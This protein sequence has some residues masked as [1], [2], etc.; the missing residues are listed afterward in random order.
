MVAAGSVVLRL[1]FFTRI[2]ANAPRLLAL[3]C[4]ALPSAAGCHS[5]EEHGPGTACDDSHPCRGGLVCLGTC[6]P[7]PDAG[8]DIT[9]DVAPDGDVSSLPAVMPPDAP[10]ADLAEAGP[11]FDLP[12][13][14][15]TGDSDAP[16]D[17]ATDVADAS[18]TEAMPEVEPDL[19]PDAVPDSIDSGS[20]LSSPYPPRPCDRTRRFERIRPLDGLQSVLGSHDETAHLTPDELT[21][22]FASSRIDG[23]SIYTTTRTTR[24]GAFTKPRLISSLKDALVD[25]CPSL[26]ADQLTIYFESTRHDFAAIYRASRASPGKDWN[27]PEQVLTISPSDSQIGDGGPTISGDGRVM[28][29]HTTRSGQLDI[30]RAEAT[31]EKGHFG[32]SFPVR[33]INTADQEARPVVSS[34]ELTIYYASNRPDGGARGGWDIWM[35]TRSSKDADFGG[36]V[37]VAE[38]NTDGYDSPAW[39]SADQCDLYFAQNTAQGER[40]FVASRPLRTADAGGD[41]P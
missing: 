39:L 7:V 32:P 24:E 21:L 19:P 29:F 4:A 11:P 35:A 14:E 16:P 6:Q 27:P 1:A 8:P 31:D 15:P 3:I 12:P 30:F 34:D 20:V 41:G 22:Y 18:D 25:Q 9:A 28:Y 40:L 33:G 23:P 26:T 2:G 37:N 5:G 38:L 17:V 13:D 10:D 36:L